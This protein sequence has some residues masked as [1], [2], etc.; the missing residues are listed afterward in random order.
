MRGELR[1]AEWIRRRAEQDAPLPLE[2]LG[3]DGVVLLPPRVVGVEDPPLLAEVLGQPVAD[4]AT[5]DG[6]VERLVERER[7]PVGPGRDLV[8]LAHRDEDL[9]GL[10]GLLVDRHLHVRGQ[11]AHDELAPLVLDQ[12]LG[13]LGADG[14]LELVVAEQDLEPAPQD[15]PLGIDLFHRHDRA[16]L[17]VLG[18]GAEGTGRRPGEADLDRVAALRLEDRREGRDGGAGCGGGEERA[19]IHRAPPW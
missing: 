11:A 14:G 17:L 13:P 4:R 18:E 7:A 2:H 1:V 10:L 19:S 15:S 12:L 9:S 5:G 16:L 3:E 8:G 6:R